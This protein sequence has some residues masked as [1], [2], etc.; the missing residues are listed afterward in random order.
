MPK[1]IMFN[2][3]FVFFR[4]YFILNKVVRVNINYERGKR[5]LLQK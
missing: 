5:L 1:F 3:F 4:K 2:I